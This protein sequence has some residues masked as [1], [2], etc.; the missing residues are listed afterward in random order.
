[1]GNSPV[2]IR[3]INQQ[4]ILNLVRQNPGISRASI[5]NTT[6]LGKATVSTIVSNFIE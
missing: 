5:V 3:E 1:M 4:R 6:N 2:S